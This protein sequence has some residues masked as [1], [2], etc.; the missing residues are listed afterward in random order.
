[1][2]AY[3]G[4]RLS[5]QPNALRRQLNQTHFENRN[6]PARADLTPPAPLSLDILLAHS[7]NQDCLRARGEE[8]RSSEPPSLE[9][10]RPCPQGQ[11]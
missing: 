1:M 8:S 4:G 5:I 2:R 7:G 6:L 9:D 11:G 10:D 3:E